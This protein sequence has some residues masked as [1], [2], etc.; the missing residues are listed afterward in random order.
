MAINKYV[1][2][3]NEF[4]NMLKGITTLKCVE[5]DI[6]KMIWKKCLMN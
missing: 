1:D 2:F 5:V 3:E 6:H 4:E